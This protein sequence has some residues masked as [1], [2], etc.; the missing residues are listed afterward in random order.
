ME[1][2]GDDK[3]T[4]HQGLKTLSLANDVKGSSARVEGQS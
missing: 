4:E 2:E 3:P 1:L